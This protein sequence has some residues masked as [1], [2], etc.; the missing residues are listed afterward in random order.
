[1]RN[2]KNNTQLGLTNN[3]SLNKI[4]IPFITKVIL[5]AKIYSN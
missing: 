1:M 3:K 2:I 5:Y 4:L